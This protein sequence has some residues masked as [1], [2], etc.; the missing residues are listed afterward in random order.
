MKLSICCFAAAMLSAAG[1]AMAQTDAAVPAR[2][3]AV[4]DHAFGLTL[5]DPYR[6][7]EGQKNP[8]FLAWLTAQGEA[9]RASL[10]AL[11]TLDRWRSTLRQASAVGVRNQQPVRFGDRVFFVRSSGSQSGVLMVREADGREHTVLDPSTHDDASGKASITTFSPSPDGTRVA[12]NIDHGG[13]ELSRITVLDTASGEPTGDNVG[14]VW[15]EVEARWLPDGSGFTYTQ[16]NPTP[17]AGDPMQGM[18]ARLH[19]LGQAASGDALL[20]AAGDGEGANAAFAMGANEFLEINAGASSPWAMAAAFGAQRER[21]VCVAPR[22]Q[23][24][25]TGAA[26]RCLAAFS[27]E[28][29]GQA[30]HEN[31]LYALSVH[32]HPNGRLLAIDLAQPNA[33][34]RTAREVMGEQAQG[35]I[36]A[37]AAARD[38]LY[39]KRMTDNRDSV[40]RI[41]YATGKATPVPL[42]YRGGAQWFS[43]QP[44][45]DGL[46]YTLQSWDRPRVT[47]AYRG[48]KT[49][50]LGLGETSPVPHDGIV[51][52]ETEVTSADGTR[53]PLTV[54]HREGI[55]RDGGNRTLVYGYGGYGLSIQPSFRPDVLAWVNAGNVAAIAHVR[56]GGERGDAWHRAGKGPLKHKGVEDFVACADALVAAGYSRAEN[57]ALNAGSMGGLI[58]GGAVARF[59]QHMGAA[60]IQVGML[61]PVRLL[62][63]V[64]GASQI[65]EVGDPRTEAG[66]KA[67]AAM[68]PYQHIRDHVAYPAVLMSVGLNDGR[69]PT[70]ETGKFAARLR[71]ARSNGRP[72]WIRTDALAGHGTESMDAE[73]LES[74]DIFAFLDAQ[75]PGRGK[76]SAVPQPSP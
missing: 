67:L 26:W 17:P 34:L 6:W 3:V 15:G 60:V 49:I 37:M 9:T 32:G 62:Q 54:L 5:P 21:R 43:A 44:D 69:V 57:V 39:V 19:V 40:E 18:R 27:D 16:M 46:V 38:G 50:D 29:L 1:G 11:P 12:V 7:M 8:E 48:G 75:L 55:A 2:K 33:S 58:V 14:V 64:N 72:V 41:D 73:A 45:T 24:L 65:A 25:V 56:G 28:V 59:P 66:M 76:G 42:P 23:A 20:L 36:E 63:G 10:D 30:L 68:D 31:T 51:V 52:E 61:N 22:A 4:V 71:A 47:Y 74:A 70:W 53:V 35:V 13:N